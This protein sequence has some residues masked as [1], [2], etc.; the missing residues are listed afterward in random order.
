MIDFTDPDLIGSRIPHPE[1]A[2]ARKKFP[3]VW[4]PQSRGISGFDDLGY[5]AITRHSDVSFIS[6]NPEIFSSYENTALIRYG[7]NYTRSEIE[8]RRAMMINMEG[9]SHKRLRNIIK[10]GFTAKAMNLME[11]LLREW[12]HKIVKGAADKIKQ[13]RSID[14][15]KEVATELPLQTICELMGIPAEDR[16]KIFE[17]SN[18]IV[19]PDSIGEKPALDAVIGLISYAAKMAEERAKSPRGD[20]VSQLVSAQSDGNLTAEEFGFFFILLSLAGSETTRNSISQGMISFLENHEQWELYK[21]TRPKTAADEIVRFSTPT[22]CVQRTAMEEI[23]IGNQVIKQGDRIGLFYA[24]ANFDED[25][26]EAP[27]DFNI[28]R[29]PNPHLGFGGGGPHYCIGKSLAIMQISMIFEEISNL[30][31][32]IQAA[33]PPI[34][35]R[36]AWVNGYKS[37]IVKA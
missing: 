10:R 33:S 34:R 27:Y 12:A 19:A 8:A 22:I 13:N 23:E 20:I 31:P 37:F 5:W 36:S 18:S 30:L 24:S 6:R 25:V 32:N 14:F 11:P 29:N 28:L 7:K 17:L 4:C 9:E 15:V 1:F 16:L 26:F 2:I 35:L 21:A 3:V